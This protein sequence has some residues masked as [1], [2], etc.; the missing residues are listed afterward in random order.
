MVED[1]EVFAQCSGRDR[2]EQGRHVCDVWCEQGA[3]QISGTWFK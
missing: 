2:A 3:F 1:K